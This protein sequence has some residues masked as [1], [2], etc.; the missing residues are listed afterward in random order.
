MSKQ[1]YKRIQA[2]RLVRE[3]LWTPVYPSDKPAQR[4]AKSRCTS[5]ARRRV[6]LRCAWQKLMMS[7]AANFGERD[8]HVVLTYDDEH[9]PS[10]AA[11]AR[12]IVRRFISQL[13][14]HRAARG[15]ELRYV[16]NVE[17]RHG[18]RRLH[19]HMVLNAA[20]RDLEAIKSLWACGDVHIERIDAYGYAQLAQ[21]LTKEAREDGAPVGARSWIPSKNLRKPE[22]PPAEWVPE[23]VQLSPPANAH[24]LEREAQ[25][26]EFG[27]YQYVMY[28]LPELPL[29]RKA[30][31]A[32]KRRIL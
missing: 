7:L 22:S 31:P 24:I 21:Y 29:D 19:H 28:L 15:D 3:V 6:N 1:R 17:G 5:A 2:G 12:K 32:P 11:G 27:R 26:N 8:L 23:G 25:E 20:G 9:L 4:A 13:R 30:R 10:D 16:Y 18:D 14:A